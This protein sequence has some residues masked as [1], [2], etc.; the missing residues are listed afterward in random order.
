[1]GGEEADRCINGWMNVY[2]KQRTT[3]ATSIMTTAK[4]DDAR[5]TIFF[6]MHF[7]S[8]LHGVQSI[9]YLSCPPLGLGA[10]PRHKLPHLH[11]REMWIMSISLR[12]A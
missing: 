11:A 2:C 1:M 7:F 3:T 9:I 5:G 4:S 6:Y 8:F 10:R 12:I